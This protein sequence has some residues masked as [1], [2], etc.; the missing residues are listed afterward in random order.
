MTTAVCGP[1]VRQ[2]VSAAAGA[3]VVLAATLTGC[4]NAAGSTP[5]P[6]SAATRW[7]SNSAARAGST[8]P[9]DGSDPAA[10]KLRPSDQDYCGM[11]EQ[12]LAAGKSILPGMTAGN[13]TLL[14]S[15]KAFITE[16]QRVAPAALASEWQ[17]LGTAVLAIVES[18]GATS[19][20]HGIDPARVGQAAAK[21]STD[22]RA[23]C[24]VDL[25]TDVSRTR[26]PK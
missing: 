17:I 19:A 7:W 26:P 24:G 4:G 2:R 9:A 15:T 3:A 21:V 22:A 1:P 8:I 25:S 10:A 6:G 16:L 12:T 20:L 23:R 13:P 18:G 11:L 5:P 14:T